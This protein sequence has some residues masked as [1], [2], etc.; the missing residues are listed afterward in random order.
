M[1]EYGRGGVIATAIFSPIAIVIGL[2]IG[3]AILH[4]CCMLV[5]ALNTSASGFEGTF[6]VTAYSEVASIASIVPVIGGPVFIVWWIVLA[7][8]GLQRMH[9]TTQGK[10]IVA[11]LIPVIL[12]CVVVGLV[13]ML[14]GAA[15]LSRMSH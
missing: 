3:A 8:M 12:C 14:A 4:V 1:H 9:K 7:V 10:A 11:I 5:G 15:I 2:F 13:M 6:R